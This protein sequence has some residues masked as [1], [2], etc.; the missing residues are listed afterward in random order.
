MDEDAE[1][2]ETYAGNI[3]QVVIQ[4]MSEDDE[5]KVASV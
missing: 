4:N 2:D 3:I 1:I 5:R